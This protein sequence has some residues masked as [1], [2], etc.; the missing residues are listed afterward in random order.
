[1]RIASAAAAVGLIAFG[2]A[3]PGFA[4][5]TAV[6]ATLALAIG[7]GALAFG[8]PRA[9]PPAPVTAFAPRRA[10]EPPAI[11]TPDVTE[12]VREIEASRPHLSP[13]IVAVVRDVAAGRLLDH[14]RLDVRR[15][16]DAARARDILGPELS[17]IVL[18]DGPVAI[19]TR[20]L[21][22]VLTRLEAL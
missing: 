18:D 21:G 6:I 20:S 7:L 4:A 17:A 3:A 19:P 8:S 14:H 1:M 9:L 10:T 11:E 15:P 5:A 2:V 13:R 16:G 12:L 22:D